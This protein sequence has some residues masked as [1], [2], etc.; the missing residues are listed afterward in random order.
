MVKNKVQVVFYVN[1]V[2]DR[3]RLNKQASKLGVNLTVLINKALKVGLPI[4]VNSLREAD[5][6]QRQASLL[7]T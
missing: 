4:V 1:T 6:V 2:E 3:D 7:K 5:R